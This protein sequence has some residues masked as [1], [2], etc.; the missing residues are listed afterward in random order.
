MAKGRWVPAL[1]A[2]LLAGV[3]AAFIMTLVL[4][5]LRLALGVPLIADVGSDRF[6]PTF[7]VSDFLALLG[8]AGGLIPAKRTALLSGFGGQLA[9]GVAGG[10]AYAIVVEFA[11]RR[12][13]E[14]EWRFGINRAGVLFV[15]LVVAVLWI[16]T[17]VVLWPVLAAN[18]VGL[19]PVAASVSTAVGLLVAYASF[20]VALILVYRFITSSSPLRQPAPIGQPVGRRAFLAGAGGLAVAMASAGGIRKLYNDS[21]LPYDGLRYSGADVKPITPNDSFYIVTKNIVDPYPKKA[22]WRLRVDGLVDTPTTYDFDDI[23][24]MPSVEQEQTIAC[25]SN[26]VGSGLISNAVWSGT[27][28][29]NLLMDVGPKE[30]VVDVKLH[31]ADGYTHDVG[32]E[33]IMEETTF[34]AYGMNG[35]PLPQRHGFPARILVPGYYGEGSVKWVTRIELFERDVEDEYYGKQGWQA[36]HFNTI[37]RF[38]NERFDPMLPAK[39]GEA[40]TLKGIAFSG[41]RGISKVEVSTDDG[42]SWEE[43]RIDYSP[44]RI[45][46][47]FWSHEWRPEKP[48]DHV[49]VVRATDGDGDL[50]IERASSIN[51]NGA[52]GYH[53]IN[54]RVEA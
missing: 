54:T 3:V 19:P 13:P 6:L 47:T 30:G 4:T 53:K 36:Q 46:W 11:T 8:D 17:V 38:D 28:L 23:A 37:S 31:A 7:N 45:A 18:N 52:S 50:Q 29:R 20:G 32:F 44:S 48:G 5:L 25:I 34:L 35:E 27:P 49:L 24:S 16:A 22:A 42:G 33:K 1:G 26:A 51:P 41:D 15:A 43:T 14:R 40:V 9:A 10:L 12:D 39:M 21:T 2:G